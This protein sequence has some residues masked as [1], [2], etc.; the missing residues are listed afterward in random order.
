MWF[1][2]NPLQ[3]SIWQGWS[4]NLKTCKVSINLQTIH[5]IFRW[6]VFKNGEILDLQIAAKL[7][8]S[9]TCTCL[10]KTIAKLMMTTEVEITMHRIQTICYCTTR[11][12]K[13]YRENQI[14]FKY[15]DSYTFR[16]HNAKESENITKLASCFNK[17]HCISQKLSKFKNTLLKD[18]QL[19]TCVNKPP[20]PY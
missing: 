19:K 7:F 3:E 1:Y 9:C 16:V 2:V 17:P 10:P 6:T 14:K 4:L 13:K 5:V 20:F 8:G 18:T 12:V 11:T 15:L